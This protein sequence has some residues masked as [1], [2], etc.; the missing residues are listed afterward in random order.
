[1]DRHWQDFQ[2]QHRNRLPAR[3][4]FVPFDS[5]EQS[6][7]LTA[8]ESP[9]C[10]SLNGPW[11]FFYASSR[12]AV[13]DDLAAP[14]AEDADWD[15]LPVPGHWQ[16]H[17]YGRPHYTNL[18]YP[19]P[20][21]PPHVPSEN[22]TA[23]YRRV[24]TLP[25]SWQGRRIMLRF[26][27]VDSAFDLFVNGKPAGYSKVSRMPSEFDITDHLRGGDNLLAVRVYQWSDGSYL[28]DQDMWWLSGIF[29]DVSLIALPTTRLAD[30]A[31]RTELDADYRN[32]TVHVGVD[33]AGS[34]GQSVD[35]LKLEVRLFDA[36]DNEVFDS[37]LQA[38]ASAG[39]HVDLSG[40][41]RDCHLWSAERPYLY[42]LVV[43]LLDARGDC[44]QA[45]AV[46]VGMRQVELRDGNLL[47]NG[48]AILMRGVNRHEFHPDF[49]RALPRQTMLQDIV[50]MKR[51]NINT[52]R[53]S[54]YPAHPHWYE[55]CDEYG[56][57]VIDEADLECHGF[58]LV[59]NW[60]Q[61]SDDPAW[62]PAYV[63]RMERMVIR[64]R[65]H[66]SIILWSLGN[67]SGF[68]CNHKAMARRA[69]ELDP[70][71]F[72]HYEGDTFA[73]TADVISQ[74][75]T[76]HEGV[77]QIGR[78]RIAVA[79]TARNVRRETYQ[80]KPFMLCEYAHAMGNGPG[81]LKE[82]QDLFHQYD[83][84]QGGCVWEWIDH[85][86]RQVA[87]DGTERIAYGGDF[88]DEPN[89]SNFI[90]D[91]L[92]MPDRTPSPG[93]IEFARVIQPVTMEP[94]DLPH[95][96]VKFY[97]R[98]DFLT[99]EHLLISWSVWHDG[100]MVESGDLASS[101]LAAGRSRTLEIPYR[102]PDGPVAG[103]YF[104]NV[105]LSLNCDTAWAP[106][107]HVVAEDQWPLPVESAKRLTTPTSNMSPI[108][109]DETAE[110]FVI[111]GESFSITFDRARGLIGYWQVG[112]Q[113]I[114][115]DGPRL[116][117]WRPPIDNERM[118]G[119]GSK[120][121]AAWIKAGLN[122][123]QHRV[124][125]VTAKRLSDQEVKVVVRSCI[126]P[127]IHSHAFDCSYIYTIRGDGRVGLEVEANPR[128]DWPSQL[129]RVGLEMALPGSMEQVEWFGGGPGEA[130]PDSRQ[131]AMIGRF[132]SHVDD[133][134]TPYV[135]PQEN[136]NRIDVR[137]CRLTDAFGHGLLAEGN[138]LL[139]FSAHR[140]T[141]DDLTRAEHHC[142]LV[143]RP[144]IT[145]HLDHQH[146]GLGSGSCG[147]GV[148]EQYQL[149]PQQFRFAVCLRGV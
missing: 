137:W 107:G 33:V 87:E 41:A 11:R 51:H 66:P 106:A 103:E 39:G 15:E 79:D 85:G 111:G 61:L 32:A 49:G 100:R 58:E 130:Y 36:E 44:L 139:N 81:G 14:D 124:D 125:Q 55:L 10:R 119:A 115:Q 53:T 131:A 28:E 67:E 109:L 92:V 68:G 46:R 91:G 140:F 2:L 8:D 105:R 83:R 96:K 116:T 126:A 86:I 127:P 94:V 118:G 52:V 78:G 76:S 97:N 148:L 89:D 50:L 25:Q 77:E 23:M 101:S 34:A 3:S 138:P 64:D 35:G 26:E 29:R 134:F 149:K 120:L 13:P 40:V 93:L 65:N 145:L 142:E 147:P 18:A 73:E 71:R 12:L 75:Y 63:D 146:N 128:G 136:G 21:D 31:V 144:T 9:W 54:H 123:L 117:F 122:R 132:T 98:Y 30:I 20:V 7:R 22:P 16:M 6:L 82:Y 95:K 45:S 102:L 60:N 99:L 1:M 90:A 141:V 104:L 80:R 48:V 19:F 112:D 113:L 38:D 108:C 129:P 143:P 42:R 59:D 114:L 88:G 135:M 37:P 57:Y 74:M 17:G 72:I 24:F 56:L 133:M 43:S 121:H 5:V 84:L 47:V 27:G 62:E 110:T 70:T 4:T 69:R